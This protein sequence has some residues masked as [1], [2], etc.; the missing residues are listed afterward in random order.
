MAVILHLEDNET[1]AGLAAPSC[2][3]QG[4]GL[5][6]FSPRQQ[7]GQTQPHRVR[8]LPFPGGPPELLLALSPRRRPS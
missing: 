3:G 6:S 4:Q 2:W 8:W 5:H 7:E 1:T